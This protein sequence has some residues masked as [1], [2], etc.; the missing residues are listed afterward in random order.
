[1]DDYLALNP[2]QTI[3]EAVQLAS[4]AD[5]TS[6]RRLITTYPEVLKIDLILRIILT[7]LPESTDPAR[8]GEFLRA[9][10]TGHLENDIRYAGPIHSV[11]SGREATFRVRRLH[12][13]PLA[14]PTCT[15][16]ITAD[17]LTLF[18][19]HRAQ[20]IDGE[21]GSLPLVSQLIE[22]FLRQSEHLRTWA[23]AT[24]LPLLRLEYEYYPHNRLEYSLASFEITSGKA[25]IDSLLSEAGERN[26]YKSN[27]G[28]D[29][30]GLVGP[31]M[32][33]NTRRKRRKR[34]HAESDTTPVYLSTASTERENDIVNQAAGGWNQANEW[35]LSL[36]VRDYPRAVAAVLQWNGPLDVDYGGW[37]EGGPQTGDAHTETS[38]YAQ[39]CLALVYT[40]SH[41]SS[42]LLQYSYLVI[43]KVAKLID[44]YSIPEL[45]IEHAS[46]L[47]DLS[48]EYLQNL[49]HASFLSSAL[50]RTDNLLTIPSKVSLQLCYLLLLS[51][52]ILESSGYQI[53]PRKLAEF[54]LFGGEA[55]QMAELRKLCHIL[56][57][58]PRD[59]DQWVQ[60]RRQVLWLRDWGVSA[61]SSEEQN[62]GQTYGVFC[63]VDMVNLEI[64]MLKVLLSS[65]RTSW[66]HGVSDSN[67]S[68]AELTFSLNRL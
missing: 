61:Q 24:L 57:S 39:A 2:A 38:D 66:D 4:E 50:L 5:I 9:A 15:Y 62:S 28:R 7:F 41:W 42:E 3:L 21:T 27:I 37:D 54:S 40:S 10:S 47:G 53:S 8:Y 51:G 13:L 6:L 43:Q 59:R 25:A 32:Y 52:T 30:R 31:W 63:R 29:L 48:S 46:D 26:E 65:S 33:G 11:L 60:I 35:L 45:N 44:M 68:S 12:L 55:E 23:I 16:Q 67:I 17:P 22:P 36:A 14:D 1:M 64:E 58:K 56:L 19:L 20:R 18:L 34:E 49:S